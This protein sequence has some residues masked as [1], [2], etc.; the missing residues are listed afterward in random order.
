ME[1]NPEMKYFGSTQGTLKKDSKIMKSTL[2]KLNEDIVMHTI[3]NSRTLNLIWRRPY[4]EAQNGK[5]RL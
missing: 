1:I 3:K 2:H 5:M 4:L